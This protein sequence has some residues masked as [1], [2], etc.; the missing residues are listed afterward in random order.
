ML[1]KMV[2][3]RGLTVLDN[4]NTNSLRWNVKVIL[5]YPLV[6]ITTTNEH[7]GNENIYTEH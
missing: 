7:F 3:M 1:L 2:T 4:Y 6:K 5:F